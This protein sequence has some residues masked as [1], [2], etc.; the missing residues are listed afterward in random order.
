M[1]I[2]ITHRT[3][4]RRDAGMNNLYRSVLIAKQAGAGFRRSKSVR[5]IFSLLLGF[6]VSSDAEQKISEFI[7]YHPP[8]SLEQADKRADSLLKLLSLD[9]K[10]QL[11]GGHDMF[12]TQGY[13]KYKIPRF[14]FSDATGGVRITDEV[15]GIIKK[16]TAFPCPVSLSATWNT[17]LAQKYATAI[18]EEC[19]AYG[20]A[21]LLGPGMN[22]YRISQCGRN[23]E[24]FGEDPFLSARMIENYVTGVQSTG[25]IATLKHF[26]CNNTDH[27]R[28]I[29]NSI[30]D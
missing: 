22:I 10:I 13:E 8:I 18:G 14:F 19:K 5:F 30:V 16:T 29:L 7:P 20:I 27:R 15:V 21:A 26:L 9:E 28:R 4:L 24:Y 6:I 23:F 2:R 17:E 11:I 3:L 25:T 12:Y 1:T